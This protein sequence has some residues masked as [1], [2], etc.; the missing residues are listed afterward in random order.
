M[1]NYFKPI[2][3][4]NTCS[5]HVSTILSREKQQK[6]N[7]DTAG[8]NPINCER[9]IRDKRIEIKKICTSTNIYWDFRTVRT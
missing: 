4:E 2:F 7:K 6:A 8:L 9:F 1:S 3:A 5:V